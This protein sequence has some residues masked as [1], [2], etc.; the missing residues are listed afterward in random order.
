MYPFFGVLLLILLILA[1]IHC[2]RRRCI[3]K[4]IKC[5]TK[6][7]KCKKLNTLIK[8]FG[9]CYDHCQDIFSS[10][11]HPWQREFGYGWIYDRLAPHAQMVIDCHPV[12]FNYKGRTWL[13]EFWKGQYGINTG[14][15][16]GIYKADEIISPSK[17]KFEIFKAISDRELL[18]L[19][20]KL[21]HHG[22]VIARLSRP[23]WWL[24]AFQMG[25]I[26]KPRDLSMDISITF[27][28]YDMLN[29]FT[30]GLE[31]SEFPP[32]TYFINGLT[33]SLNF[34]TCSTCSCNW[35]RR[36]YLAYV[37]WKNRCFCR[38]FLCLTRPFS[39]S[40]DRILYLYEYAPFAFRKMFTIHSYKASKRKG[41]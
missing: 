37:Q 34:C 40:M 13:I 15:E 33:V 24:T 17:R 36:C 26:S 7:E 28:D 4:K 30:D 16:I 39:I 5:M 20:M 32:E 9:Y 23:H 41:Y 8:P 35:F 29:A 27:P 18:M 6:E 19:S 25:S 14:G 3:I 1:C 22:H 10:T 38:L 31:Q 11:L 2:Y 21:K 12:Y